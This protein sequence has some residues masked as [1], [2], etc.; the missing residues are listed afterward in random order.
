VGWAAEEQ[1]GG[2]EQ[3]EESRGRHESTYGCGAGERG[4]TF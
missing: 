1:N 3:A 4:A 2:E